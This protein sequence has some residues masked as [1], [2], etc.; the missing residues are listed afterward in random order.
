[1]PRK[2]FPTRVSD[3]QIEIYSLKLRRLLKIGDEETSFDFLKIVE[4]DLGK[5]LR[6]FSL[7]VARMEEMPETGADAYTDFYPPTIIL[8][9]DIYEG[10]YRHEHRSRFTLAHE[11]GH[12][13]LHWGLP[14]A[15]LAPKPSKYIDHSIT[16]STRVMT[17]E[18]KRIENEAHRFAG[19]FLMPRSIVIQHRLTPHKLA[20][21]CNVS[22]EAASKRIQSILHEDDKFDADGIRGLFGPLRSSNGHS[23]PKG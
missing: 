22:L 9:E 2:T 10:V 12:L 19:A 3:A 6:G 23:G 8:R 5:A 4:N 7:R 18:E 11:L 16:R 15:R 14:R 1:M 20:T 21:R 17:D 13:A